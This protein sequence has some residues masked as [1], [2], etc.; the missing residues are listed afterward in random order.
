M[1]KVIRERQDQQDQ[2]GLQQYRV[3]HLVFIP[4]VIPF[5]QLVNKICILFV[6]NNKVTMVSLLIHI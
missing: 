2:Q 6:I 1:I 4:L 3:P 5:P